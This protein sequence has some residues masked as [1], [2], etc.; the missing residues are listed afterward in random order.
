M[1]LLYLLYAHNYISYK[2][3][4]IDEKQLKDYQDCLE[5]FSSHIK[6]TLF[7]QENYLKQYKIKTLNNKIRII[8]IKK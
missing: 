5:K 7:H 1:E 6:N 2:I 4:Y 8:L 3:G